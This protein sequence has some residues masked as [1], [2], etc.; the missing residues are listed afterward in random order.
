MR[1][2]LTLLAS[3]ALACTGSPAPDANGYDVQLYFEG[4][5]VGSQLSLDKPAVITVHRIEQQTDRC[6]SDQTA[7]DPTTE[8]PITLVSATC[9]D[10]C[11]V[12]P[13]SITGNDG[14]VA[15]ETTGHKA[16]NT[17]LRVQVRS[18]VD[19]SEWSDAYPLAFR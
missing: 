18:Q 5:P 9:D 8:T 6:G 7:C 3:F 16:G 15:L 11:V 12:T 10:L 4:V 2:F 1:V 14:A 19:G 13:T 17:T